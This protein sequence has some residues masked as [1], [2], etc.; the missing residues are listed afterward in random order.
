MSTKPATPKTSP[1]VATSSFIHQDKVASPADWDASAI[2]IV[3]VDANPQSGSKSKSF[4]RIKP[5][6]S[7]FSFIA[8]CVVYSCERFFFL[9]MSRPIFGVKKKSM[10]KTILNE[11]SFIN[12]RLNE[13]NLVIILYNLIY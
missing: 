4:L 9:K 13:Y 2:A 1:K 6:I 5:V 3:H 12:L 11:R 10:N 7:Q 8:G